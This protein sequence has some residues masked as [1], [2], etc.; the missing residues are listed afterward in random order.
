MWLQCVIDYSIGR[1][2][3]IG[4]SDAGDYR[5]DGGAESRRKGVMH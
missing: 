5:A 2:A 4:Q 1:S 3:A